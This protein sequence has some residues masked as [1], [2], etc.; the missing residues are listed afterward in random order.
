LDAFG[1]FE[2]ADQFSSQLGEL[3]ELTLKRRAIFFL[4]IE[5]NS[6]GNSISSKFVG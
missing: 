3:F 1:W 4:D 2:F 5:P 6:E